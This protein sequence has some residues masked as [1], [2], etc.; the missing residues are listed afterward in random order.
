MVCESGIY[1]LLK[2]EKLSV[3]LSRV[4]FGKH[5]SHAI[6]FEGVLAGRGWAGSE[7]DFGILKAKRARE[8][9]VCKLMHYIK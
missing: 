5:K 8:T 3:C 6:K 9:I 2:I 1:V 7:I 4:S